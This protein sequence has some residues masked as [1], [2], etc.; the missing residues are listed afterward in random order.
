MSTAT[1]QKIKKEVK[2]ELKKELMRE[3]ITPLLGRGKDPEGEYRPEFIKEI[4][5]AAREKSLYT[6][7]PKTFLK[8]IG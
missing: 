6:Y 2:E 4:L 3:I 8:R 5:K 7:H 1:I